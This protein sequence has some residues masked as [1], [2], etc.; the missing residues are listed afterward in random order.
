[1]LAC[2]SQLLGDMEAEDSLF[3]GEDDTELFDGV[4]VADADCIIDDDKGGDCCN[5]GV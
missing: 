5:E 4:A 1:M 3:D 2:L